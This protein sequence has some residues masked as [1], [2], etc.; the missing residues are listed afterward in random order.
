M[1]DADQALGSVAPPKARA[2]WGILALVVAGVVLLLVATSVFLR[3]RDSDAVLYGYGYGSSEGA[4][5]PLGSA[6]YAGLLVHPGT[7]G[8]ASVRLDLRSVHPRIVSNSANATVRL[9]LCTG[10]GHRSGGGIVSSPAAA[11][12][13]MTDFRRGPVDLGPGATTLVLEVIPQK[14]G[15]VDIAGADVGYRRGIRRGQQHAGIRII[16][17]AR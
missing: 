14:A 4:P 10:A 1:V 8:S 3:W 13:T 2:R 17:D 6:T 5:V 16:L 7:A 11:C 12:A 9:L 15:T